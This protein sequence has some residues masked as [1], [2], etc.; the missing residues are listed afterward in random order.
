MNI[1]ITGGAGF[2]GSNLVA[3]HL[4]KG[5]TVHVVDNLSTGS[6]RNIEAFRT[7][8]KFSFD[9]ADLLV[10]KRLISAVV[11]ADRI[12]H[13]AAIVGVKKVLLD[14]RAVMETNIAAT[15]RLFRAADAAHPE[16]QILVASSSEV[17]GFNT[18]P[19][20]SETDD[21]VLRSAGRLRWCYAVTKLTDEYLAYAF[22]K[23]AGVHVSIV[24]LFNTIGLNQTGQ[25]GMVVPNFVQQAVRNQPL[26]IFG[27]GTQTRSFCDVRDTIVNL[28]LLCTNPASNGEIVNVGND[29]EISITDLAKLIIARSQSKSEIKYQSYEQAYGLEFEDITHR[30]PILKKMYALTNHQPQWTLVQT[31]DSLIDQERMLLN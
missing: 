6:L 22:M 25:Y 5:D 21:I 31:I 10:W 23:S 28:D 29:A 17:Y 16:I 14:P 4:A 1:L 9:Q 24:R 30:R 20:F 27:D 13:L 19:A 11:K 18:Q 15:D 2:I 8:P 12:Y 26:S 7:H 3:H